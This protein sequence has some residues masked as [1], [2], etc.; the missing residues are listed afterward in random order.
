MIYSLEEIKEKIIPVA[1]KHQISE[2]YLF[3]SYARQEADEDSDIDFM[4]TVDG[5]DVDGIGFFGLFDE[6]ESLFH[7]KIDIVTKEN[8]SEGKNFLSKKIYE[9]ILR[10]GVLLYEDGTVGSRQRIYTLN[11]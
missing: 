1:I 11:A 9:Q 4:V 2:I 3:G 7:K 8:M 6:L 10:E 5:S